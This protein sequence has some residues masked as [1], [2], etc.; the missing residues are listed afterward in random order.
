MAITASKKDIA[1]EIQND[2][3]KKGIKVAVAMQARDL[4]T[5]A[6]TD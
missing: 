2:L 6:T 1:I 3:A 5:D 4:G